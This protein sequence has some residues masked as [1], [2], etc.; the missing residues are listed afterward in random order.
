MKSFASKIKTV[1]QRLSWL[2]D[3]AETSE[4]YLVT[5]TAF[6]MFDLLLI[7]KILYAR[8]LI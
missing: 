2:H 6:Y 4:Y 8:I 1:F 3:V 7:I 5:P